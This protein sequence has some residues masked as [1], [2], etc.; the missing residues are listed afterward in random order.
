MGNK[1]NQCKHVRRT[2]TIIVRALERNTNC[3]EKPKRIFKNVRRKFRPINIART[4]IQNTH[5]NR[6][7]IINT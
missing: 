1:A 4:P 6:G 7:E 5:D 3:T 2:D